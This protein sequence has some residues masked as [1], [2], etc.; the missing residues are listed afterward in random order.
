MNLLPNHLPIRSVTTVNRLLYRSLAMFS[1][2]VQYRSTNANL[3]VQ[4]LLIN[5]VNLNRRSIPKIKF[6][7]VILYEYLAWITF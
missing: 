7:G 2:V 6:V 4:T 3:I 5:S 1:S